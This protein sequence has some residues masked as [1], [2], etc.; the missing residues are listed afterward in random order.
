M[1]LFSTGALTRGA[2]DEYVASELG[3]SADQVISRDMF[4]VNRQKPEL[5]GAGEEF[6]SAPKLD[7]LACAFV[8]LEA[9]LAAENDHDVSVYCC[10]DNE[11]VGSNT[12]QGA[13]STVLRDTLERMNAALGFSREDYHCAVAKSMLVSCD[14]AHALHP[15]RPEVADAENRPVLG[16]GIVVKEA[17]NQKYCTDAFSR[18]AFLSVCEAAGVPV[19]TFA[20][21]S[22]MAGGST[23]GNLSNTQVSMHGVDVGLPQLA[24]HSSYETCAACD[25]KLSIDALKAFFDAEIVIH[26]SD[27]IELK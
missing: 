26:G 15:N 5:W 18:A 13:M 7:D 14:N 3:V 27:S 4:L 21:R 12:K 6:L 9:F 17:A 24:M 11:E 22:D 16:G 25:V 23:L 1:P 2:L 20:N 8:S 19:Q 10:F